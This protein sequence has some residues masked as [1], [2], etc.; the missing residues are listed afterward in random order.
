MAIST[1]SCVLPFCSIPPWIIYVYTGL[2]A[3]AILV[4]VTMLV[5][6]QRKCNNSA[7][8][9]GRDGPLVHVTGD[10]VK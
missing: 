2:A 7:K 10:F 6:A 9:A 1:P 8:V 5:L 4:V 3:A